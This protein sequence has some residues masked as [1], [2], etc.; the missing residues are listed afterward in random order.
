[1]WLQTDSCPQGPV[2]LLT[3][4]ILLALVSTQ[5]APV[6]QVPS[7]LVVKEQRGV[8]LKPAT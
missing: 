6:L 8:D 1:M 5:N 4:Q 3:I 7:S 2:S